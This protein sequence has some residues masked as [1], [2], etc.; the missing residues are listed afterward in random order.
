MNYAV[1]L[2]SAL[3]TFC[4]YSPVQS[5]ESLS[6]T[7]QKIVPQGDTDPFAKSDAPGRV[8]VSEIN[9]KT[10]AK[11][12]FYSMSLTPG[13]TGYPGM[14]IV[15]DK[16]ADFSKYDVLKMWVRTDYPTTFLQTVI[17]GADGVIQDIALTGLASRGYGR[18][19]NGQWNAAYILYKEK[20]GWIRFGKQMDHTAIKSVTLYTCS[21]YLRTSRTSYE[22]DFGGLELLT[23]Q[24]AMAE[25]ASGAGKTAPSSGSILMQA[26][27]ITVWSCDPT[28]KVYHQTPLPIK[29]GK[30]LYAEG[31]GG[32]YVPVVCNL[33]PKTAT[34]VTSIVVGKLACGKSSISSDLALCR[35]VDT[36]NENMESHPDPLP[37]VQGKIISVS[38]NV[39]TTIWTTWRIPEGTKAGTYRGKI[40][41][42]LS[43]GGKL[44][45]PVELKVYGFDLPAQSHLQSAYTVQHFYGGVPYFE[46]RSKRYWGE[47]MARYTPRY[48][49][50]A[51]NM[52]IDFGE[53]RITP[54]LHNLPF[55]YLKPE[56]RLQYIQKYHFNP[57]YIIYY[58]F[59]NEFIAMNPITPEKI[60]AVDARIKERADALKAIGYEEM[61]I[62]K[63]ADEPNEETLKLTL[64]AADEAK[65]TIPKVQSFY[66]GATNKIPDALI[67]RISTYCMA[68]GAFDFTGTQAKERLAAGEKLWTYASDYRANYAYD[69]L[70]LRLNYWLYWKFNITGVHFSHHMHE[71][72]LTYPNDTYPHSDRL[73]EI[74]S[75]RF[76]MLRLGLQD[77]E[78]LWLLNDLIKRTST[79]DKAI[80]SLLTVPEN[81]A[82]NEWESTSDPKILQTRRKNIAAAIEK[83]IALIRK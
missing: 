82:I 12:K 9:S 34:Q 54:E 71:C 44:A 79:T 30:S 31:A 59:I 55:I 83:L 78:Y 25:I 14:N 67:G 65:K 20:P 81:L 28:D 37:L 38:A 32:E 75:V 80:L 11:G 21:D 64:L 68:W 7:A 10:P 57:A 42:C 74:P 27:D 43:S 15:F 6:T 41:I 4:I 62:I 35:Y 18:I 73:K 29:S 13:G 5:M 39:N 61:S 46:E 23:K 1:L 47:E 26:G 72:F 16:P 19:R 66:A 70:E 69:P 77:Y 60:A 40:T 45:V 17:N 24:E 53:H 33:K 49:E 76:E 8:T 52:I 50:C 63:I 58:N 22:Y 51:N 48:I 2:V 3:L 36:I 56:E